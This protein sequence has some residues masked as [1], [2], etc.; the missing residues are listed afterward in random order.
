MKTPKL[1]VS[2]Q[3]DVKWKVFQGR[4]IWKYPFSQ[5]SFDKDT[6]DLAHGPSLLECLMAILGFPVMSGVV[7]IFPKNL[8]TNKPFSRT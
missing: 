7:G 6:Q 1:I 5:R 4:I 3:T 2:R 8:T